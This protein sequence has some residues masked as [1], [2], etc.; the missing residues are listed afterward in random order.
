MIDVG[1]PKYEFS[2]TSL[3]GMKIAFVNDTSTLYVRTYD[4]AGQP[5]FP[6][7]MKVEIF[8]SA[9]TKLYE[10]DADRSNSVSGLWLKQFNFKNIG[11]YLVR[12]KDSDGNRGV[13]LVTAIDGRL[14]F[15][16]YRLRSILDKSEK[17]KNES[18]GYSD[19][20]LF[21]YLV[22]GLGYFNTVPPVTSFSLGNLPAY[23]DDIVI[24]LAQLY[25]LQAQQ[26]YAVDTDVSYN[27]Q[28]LSLNIDHFSK[29]GN[30]YEQVARRILD[31][32]RKVKW[33]MGSKTVVLAMFNPERAMNYVFTQMIVPGFPYFVWGLGMYHMAT[34]KL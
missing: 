27:D 31:N 16:L 28:G 34:W 19:A 29:L 3:A 15:L 10:G 5:Y 17:L 14:E 24:E 2:E 11:S 12:W 25:A 8:D 30:V 33:Q 21:M 26:L 22:N 20:D 7:E 32:I 9:G 4:D 1:R 6:A 13:N 18:W 23:L